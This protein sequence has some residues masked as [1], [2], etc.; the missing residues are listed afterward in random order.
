MAEKLLSGKEIS[1]ALAEEAGKVAGTVCSPITDLRA[2][3][4]YR[5][6]MVEV[7]TRR[8][9]MAALARINNRTTK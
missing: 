5:C 1:A 2:S 6:D 9:V 7:L 4:G 3:L 8:A